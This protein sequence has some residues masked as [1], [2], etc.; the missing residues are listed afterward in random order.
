MNT[1]I[2]AEFRSPEALLDAV[3]RLRALGYTRLDA[4]TPYPVPI[5]ESAIGVR[6]SKVPVVALAFALLGG[7]LGYLVQ[8]WTNG[9]DYP[10]DVGGRPLHSAPAFVPITFESAVLAAALSALVAMLAFTRLPRPWH[11]VFEVEGFESASVDGFWIGV[12][13]SDPRF[14]FAQLSAVLRDAGA[15]RVAPFGGLS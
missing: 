1:G 4:F 3:S 15:A 14:V 11:P 7:S 2:V 12:D 9:V 10:L 5:V 13:L 6:R 8:W